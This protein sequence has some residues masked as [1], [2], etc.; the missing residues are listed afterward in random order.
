MLHLMRRALT[1]RSTPSLVWGHGTTSWDIAWG[2]LN[3]AIAADLQRHLA[4][5]TAVAS[6]GM[7]I[8]QQCKQPR[9]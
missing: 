3:T 6:R 5:R 2:M 1:R 8:G 9:Q 7:S 4:T